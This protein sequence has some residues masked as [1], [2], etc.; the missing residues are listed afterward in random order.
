MCGLYDELAN[1][2]PKDWGAGT[3]M[4][5]HSDAF[6]ENFE[7]AFYNIVLTFNGGIPRGSAL[8]LLEKQRPLALYF[9]RFASFEWSGLLFE[10][11]SISARRRSH[12]ELFIRFVK[13]RLS[14]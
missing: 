10:A 6:R 1:C 14:L 12:S 3:E 9:S 8:V 5:A 13:L 7:E 4:A 11:I 2:S